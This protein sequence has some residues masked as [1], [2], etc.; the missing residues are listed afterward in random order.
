MHSSIGPC[1]VEGTAFSE[2]I[3]RMDRDDRE[4]PATIEMT[5]AAVCMPV[6]VETVE[7]RPAANPLAELVK[8]EIGWILFAITEELGISE[9]YS[10]S[11][12]EFSDD[13]GRTER[14]STNEEC[15]KCV[16][17]VCDFVE[18]DARENIPLQVAERLDRIASELS[19]AAQRILEIDDDRD[20]AA[21]RK[22]IAVGK[23][24]A[25]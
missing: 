25:T 16:F 18:I 2:L 20:L 9:A 7:R 3:P 13:P 22:M 12:I 8:D 6:H 10:S 24:A 1:L 21:F 23:R 5:R 11:G 15:A 14:A 17:S 4:R 19:E